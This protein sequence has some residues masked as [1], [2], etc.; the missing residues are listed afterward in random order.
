MQESAVLSVAAAPEVD[1]AS[2]YEEHA[3]FIG[4]VIWRLTGGGAHVDDLLQETFLVA[5]KKRA[6]LHSRQQARAWLYAIAAHLCQRYNRGARRF[7]LFRNRYARE[8]EGSPVA[9]PDQELEKEQ[10][11][12]LVYEALG[13]LPFKHRET[14]VLYELEGFEGQEIAEMIGVPVGTVWTRLHHARKKFETQM[15]R[16][17]SKDTERAGT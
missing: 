13:R 5:F 9:R 16:R 8:P 7:S 2:L 12:A 14:F 10:A 1:V 3:P 15:R 6:E 4:R 11:V 17:L